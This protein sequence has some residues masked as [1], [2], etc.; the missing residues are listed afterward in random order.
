[1]GGIKVI[2]VAS[3]TDITHALIIIPARALSR[4]SIALA[5]IKQRIARGASAISAIKRGV[6]ASA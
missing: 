6:V 1:M 5:A 4:S 2:E 3:V